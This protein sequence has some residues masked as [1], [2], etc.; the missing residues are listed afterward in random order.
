MKLNRNALLCF[1]AGVGLFTAGLFI[2]IGVS[3]LVAVGS[4]LVLASLFVDEE[5]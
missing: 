5:K 1:L 4:L 3:A 2:V